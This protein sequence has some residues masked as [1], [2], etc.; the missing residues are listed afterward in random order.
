MSRIYDGPAGLYRAKN[1]HVNADILPCLRQ[2]EPG[3]SDKE[4][5][6]CGLAFCVAYES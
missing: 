1:Y 3:V 4:E 5:G 2:R 6:E